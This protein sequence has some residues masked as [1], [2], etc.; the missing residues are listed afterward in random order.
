VRELGQSR[1]FA[2]GDHG[3]VI[4][5]YTSTYFRTAGHCHSESQAVE[6]VV[7]LGRIGLPDV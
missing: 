1:S 5:Y 3:Q 4:R 6:F 2:C 7:V